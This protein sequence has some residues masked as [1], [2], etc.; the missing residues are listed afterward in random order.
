[1]RAEA[2]SDQ[3]RRET[4]DHDEDGDAGGIT[5]GLPTRRGGEGS[6]HLVVDGCGI[7]GCDWSPWLEEG[8]RRR[9]CCLVCGCMET[10]LHAPEDP[11][12]AYQSYPF[13][14]TP[15]FLRECLWYPRP[16][17][18]VTAAQLLGS[19][20]RCSQ[21]GELLV[22]HEE[23]DERCFDDRGTPLILLPGR[24]GRRHRRS[25]VA[26]RGVGPM[27]VVIAAAMTM[28][29][30]PAVVQACSPPCAPSG[31]GS[32]GMPSS[33]SQD[34]GPRGAT[35]SSG[36]SGGGSV[37]SAGGL[38]SHASAGSATRG[39]ARPPHPSGHRAGH[40]AAASTR[41]MRSDVGSS[42]RCPDHRA[43]AGGRPP[44]AC[45]RRPHDGADGAV[46]G[47]DV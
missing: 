10:R 36:S 1:M 44:G 31:P 37:S 20:G 24:P 47:W 34:S 32:G 21:C 43:D 38:S 35:P 11:F 12:L 23:L 9:R 18:G 4:D 33:S 6:G 26:E 41:P 22:D 2:W 7:A 13:D 46:M 30:G 14:E 19:Q 16:A 3:A 42:R 15:R 40:G 39:H 25:S 5:P 29:A 27:V 17:T 45:R 8:D 28:L